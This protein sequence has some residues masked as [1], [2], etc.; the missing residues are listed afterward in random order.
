MTVLPLSLG[1]IV[2]SIRPHSAKIKL[3]GHHSLCGYW[4]RHALSIFTKLSGK[5]LDFYFVVGTDL[6]SL[7]AVFSTNLSVTSVESQWSYCP[8]IL[9][10][11]LIKRW[12]L[13]SIGNPIVE[14]RRS[15]DR[16]ISTMGFPILVRCLLYIESAPWFMLLIRSQVVLWRADNVYHGLVGLKYWVWNCF[17][18][19]QWRHNERDGI[20]YDQPHDC[21][22]NHLFRRRSKKT[23]NSASLAFVKGIHWWPVNSLHKKPVTQKMF[24]FDDIIMIHE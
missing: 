22:L 20:A 24:P 1:N 4:I 7:T 3:G 2:W 5:S 21:L 14:I 15:Y 9:G 23:S 10:P 12:H 19:L 16:L 6:K 11:D 17:I 8:R 13:T 18:A